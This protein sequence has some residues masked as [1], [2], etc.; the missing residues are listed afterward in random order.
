MIHRIKN[1][2]NTTGFVSDDFNEARTLP[3]QFSRGELVET[4]EGQGIVSQIGVFS[5]YNPTKALRG[6]FYTRLY[7]VR[8]DALI[9]V[10]TELELLPLNPEKELSPMWVDAIKVIE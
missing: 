5:V 3:I 8:V 4:P 9:R 6:K 1:V 10:I 7:I 2:N